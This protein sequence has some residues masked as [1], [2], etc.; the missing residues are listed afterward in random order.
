MKR[1]LERGRH[2]VLLPLPLL[3]SPPDDAGGRCAGGGAG[4]A[5]PGAARPGRRSQL[6]AG[7]QT[8]PCAP[9]HA[10]GLPHPRRR[11]ADTPE[12]LGA[13]VV[14]LVSR[15]RVRTRGAVGSGAWAG[16]PVPLGLALAPP[17]TT[18]LHLA[19]IPR[20]PPPGRHAL[21]HARRSGVPEGD[22]ARLKYGR[23][24]RRLR[25]HTATA[26]RAALGALLAAWLLTLY[27]R[28]R[29]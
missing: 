14:H 2:S 24:Q 13:A 26:L 15:G 29:Q 27:L 3:R 8:P 4:P 18:I 5:P 28:K 25:G 11:D 20:L 19:D 21:E 9:L 16:R 1:A 17:L 12:L 23:L 6:L 22:G 10:P 7:W